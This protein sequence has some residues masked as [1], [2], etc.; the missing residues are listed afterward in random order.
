[1]DAPLLLR[2]GNALHAVHAAFI[3]QPAVNLPSFDQRNHLL[4]PAHRGNARGQFFHPPTLRLGVACVHAKHFLGEECGLVATR[5][6]AD[7]QDHV[8]FVVGIARQQQDFQFFFHP[9]DA[10]LQFLHFFVRQGLDFRI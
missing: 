8:F 1:M 9:R 4:Q 2:G 3:L 5:P 10:F 6:G 7:F